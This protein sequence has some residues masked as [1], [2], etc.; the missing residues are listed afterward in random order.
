MP[1][2]AIGYLQQPRALPTRPQPAAG[3][4]CAAPVQSHL[5]L[6]L[7]PMQTNCHSAVARQA[8]PPGRAS[9][10]HDG[11]GECL[12]TAADHVTR[13]RLGER[14]RRTGGIAKPVSCGREAQPSLAHITGGGDFG[15][16]RLRADVVVTEAGAGQRQRQRLILRRQAA[17]PVEPASGARVVAVGGFKLGPLECFPGER[18]V[19]RQRWVPL[20]C[21]D[22]RLQRLAACCGSACAGSS[23]G[24]SAARSP[25]VSCSPWA[26]ARS[27]HTRARSG[28]RSPASPRAR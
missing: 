4:L 19:V 21:P 13:Q 9:I 26:R 22:C 8:A 15:E 25:R 6:T 12:E 16:E 5:N 24:G 23:A 17:C 7:E 20:R 2:A 14:A 11:T 1:A 18:G 28:S 27:S 10:P 3:A